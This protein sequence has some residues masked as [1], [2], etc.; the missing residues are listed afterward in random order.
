MTKFI[1]VRHGETIWNAA[2]RFQGQSDINLSEKG[3]WQAMRTGE[4]LA[5]E[6][7]DVVYASNLIR[8]IDTAKLILYGRDLD[9]AVRPELRELSFGEWEGLTYQEISAK[10][11]GALERMRDN[12]FDFRPPGGETWSEMRDRVVG[13]YEEIK[14]DHA[15]K[16][17]LVVAHINPVRVMLGE[18]LGSNLKTAFRLPLKNCSINILEVG[19]KRTRLVVYNDTCHLEDWHEG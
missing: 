18:V 15:N 9:I 11:P 4:H 19:P 6:Q 2:K 12:G 1:L 10:S 5:G 13:V 8:C 14:R 7:I 3:R 16:T 17:V